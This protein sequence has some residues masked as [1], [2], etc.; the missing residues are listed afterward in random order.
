[1]ADLLESGQAGALEIEITPAMIEAGV[2]AAETWADDYGVDDM[3]AKDE[4]IQLILESAL[5]QLRS[6]GGQGT[7]SVLPSERNRW[8]FGLR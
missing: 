4:L 2:D 8:R 6:K 3:P 7:A 1:M 5:R